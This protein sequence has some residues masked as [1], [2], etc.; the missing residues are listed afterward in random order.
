[1]AWTPE[2][3]EAWFELDRFLKNHLPHGEYLDLR[4]QIAEP[5]KEF[6]E[7][8]PPSGMAF[9]VK[10]DIPETIIMRYIGEVAADKLSTMEAALFSKAVRSFWK[11]VHPEEPLPPSVRKLRPTHD[12]DAA[13]ARARDLHNPK[14]GIGAQKAAERVYDELQPK[15]QRSTFVDRIR[16][17][18]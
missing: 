16:R 18:I 13:V 10:S 12:D 3:Y 5:L 15:E 6:L 17:K 8:P 2:R 14:K 11:R 7:P 1:M 4:R 9:D